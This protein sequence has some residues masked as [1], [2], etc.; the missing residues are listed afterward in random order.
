VILLQLFFSFLVIGSLSFGGGYAMI[1][2]IQREIV[3]TRHWISLEEFTNLISVSQMT[4][5]PVAVNSAT[6]IGFRIAGVPGAVTATAGVILVPAVVVFILFWLTRRHKN[7]AVVRGAL[8]AIKPVLIALIVYSA[9]SI[10]INVFTSW[11][12]AVL[13]AGAF[14]IIL[15]TSLHPA[16][17]ILAAALLGFFFQ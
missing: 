15:L 5:G 17:L 11:F 3:E 8:T 7:T 16:Y 2:L 9:Y 12:S 13:A 1:P 4:P 10:G 14:F 6:Y